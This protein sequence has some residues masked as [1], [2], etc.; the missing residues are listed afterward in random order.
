MNLTDFTELLSLFASHASISNAICS[1]RL[2]IRC[3]TKYKVYPSVCVKTFDTL[4]N[5]NLLTKPNQQGLYKMHRSTRLKW[6]QALAA[7]MIVFTLFCAPARVSASGVTVNTNEARL[8]FPEKITFRVAAQAGANIDRVTLIYGVSAE[9]CVNGQAR[10]EMNFTPAPTVDLDWEWDFFRAGDVPPGAEVWWQWEIHASDGAELLTDVQRLVIED[11]NFQ[12]KSRTDGQVTL[13][14]AE[15]TD[16]FGATLLDI[17]TG[18]LERLAEISNLTPTGHVRITIYPSVDDLIG[19]LNHTTDWMG[20]VAF[21]E[22]RIILLAIEPDTDMVWPRDSIPHELAHLVFDQ[23]TANCL[24]GYPPSWLNE[25]FAMYAEGSVSEEDSAPVLE[26]LKNGTLQS[27][28]SIANGFPADAQRAHLAYAQSKMM[29]DFIIQTYGVETFDALL[30]QF[31]NG[32]NTNDALIAV[33]GL[34]TNGLDQTWRASLGFGTAPTPDFATPTAAA[35]FTAI[36]TL[37]LSSPFQPQATATVAPPTSTAEPT[38]AQPATESAGVQAT[39]QSTAPAA[40]TS[41]G[42]A[43]ML[44]IGGALLAVLIAALAAFFMLRKKQL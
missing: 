41:T 37:A 36:P 23:R 26:A 7:W 16:T 4:Y 18:G 17:A 10:H 5:Y 39:P 25:G 8:D 32:E 40:E 22:Y 3:L 43:P 29:V 28:T 33:F 34:D 24:G 2:P 31:T 38:A 19:A 1:V 15:G 35:T 12:W 14:W 20:G 27:F 44:W 6:L 13:Y 30:D 21:P 42:S 9:R 11:P